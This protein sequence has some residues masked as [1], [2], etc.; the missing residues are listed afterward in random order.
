MTTDEK[1]LKDFGTAMYGSFHEEEEFGFEI[2]TACELN[3]NE[4]TEKL[5]LILSPIDRRLLIR[6]AIAT[7]ELRS[8]RL[9][10]KEDMSSFLEEHNL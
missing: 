5:W 9:V 10:K 1:P 8:G 4:S 6:R 2:F 3:V 7:W